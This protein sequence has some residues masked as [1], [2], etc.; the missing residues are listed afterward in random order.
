MSF[1]FAEASILGKC[2]GTEQHANPINVPEWHRL[3]HP[4]DPGHSPKAS[5]MP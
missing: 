2:S 5:F 1:Y 3:K 4:K